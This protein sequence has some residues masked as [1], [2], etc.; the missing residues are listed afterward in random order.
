MKVL[1]GIAVR[2]EEKDE[3]AYLLSYLWCAAFLPYSPAKD[4]NIFG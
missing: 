3:R 1:Y 2:G 4:K